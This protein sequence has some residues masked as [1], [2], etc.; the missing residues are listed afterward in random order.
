MNLTALTPPTLLDRARTRW[1]EIGASQPDLAPAIAL[2]RLLVARTIRVVNRLANEDLNVRLSPAELAQKLRAGIPALRGEGMVLPVT[3]LGP[4]VGETCDDLASGEAGEAAHRVRACL[5]AGRVDINSLLNASFDRNQMAI[6]MKAMQEAIAPDILW[7]AAELAVGP[8]AYVTARATFPMDGMGVLHLWPHGYC[9]ACGSWPA[10]AE[11]LVGKNQLRCSFCGL[12]WP[13][14]AEGC[15]YCGK[16][17]KLTAA[18]TTQDSASRVE[19]CLE[20]GAYLKCLAV[21][22]PTP[23]ELLPIEDLASASVDVL[24]AQ[25]GFGRPTLPDLGGPSG[26]PCTEMEPAP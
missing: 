11:E 5:D 13:K 24:A 12:D 2:Q 1:K 7:L 17:S 14:R 19:L 8:V 25:R 16:S 9:P 4:L 23:F 21:S 3:L 10:F 20:C 22:A 18:K 26:L 15:N 6:R